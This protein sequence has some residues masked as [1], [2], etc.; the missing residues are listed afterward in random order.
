[1]FRERCEGE[2]VVPEL[3]R[4][5]KPRSGHAGEERRIYVA[6]AG[7]YDGRKSAYRVLILFP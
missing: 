2:C 1:M 3:P 4:A 5:L 6:L 7:K